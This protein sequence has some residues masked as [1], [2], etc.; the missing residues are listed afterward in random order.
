MGLR[1]TQKFLAPILLNIPGA[2]FFL[3]FSSI[4][5][6]FSSYALIHLMITILK[7]SGLANILLF[8]LY[9]KQKNKMKE[10]IIFMNLIKV[11]RCIF[12]TVFSHIWIINKT[13]RHVQSFILYFFKFD[14]S[15]KMHLLF[16]I[17]SNMDH[18]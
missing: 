7:K 5:L 2:L 9:H 10:H 15:M 17:F 18:K 1:K 3:C 13:H 14:R 12:C 6:A 11:W 16:C 8:D 4:P